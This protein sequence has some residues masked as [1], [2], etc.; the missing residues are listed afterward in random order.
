M[1]LFIHHIV[2]I[3]NDKDYQPIFRFNFKLK[4]YNY[5]FNEIFMLFD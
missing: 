5:D 3:L 1:S 2:K 4:S